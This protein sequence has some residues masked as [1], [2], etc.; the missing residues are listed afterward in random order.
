MAEASTAEESAGRL[1]PCPDCGRPCS[2]SAVSCPQ[3]GHVFHRAAQ[4][5]QNPGIAAVL[6]LVLAGV[7]QMYWG[8]VLRGFAWL[9]M[10]NGFYI[11]SIMSQTPRAIII[12]L[13]L[14]LL[15]IYDAAT[16]KP[17]D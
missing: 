16:L 13:V 17:A 6:S 14:H 3:C 2:Q 15:C 4:R 7:G 12:G 1:T 9:V 8:L 5:G 10:V 11:V